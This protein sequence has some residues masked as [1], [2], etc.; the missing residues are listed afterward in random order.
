MTGGRT[1]RSARVLMDPLPLLALATLAS[2]SCG[3]HLAGKADLVPKTVHT[4]SVPPFS[5]ATTRYRL[6]DWLPE[7]ISREFISRTRYRIVSDP[8]QA[9]AVVRGSVLNY[10]SYPT[11]LDP[12]TGRASAIEMHVLM[13]VSL[14]ERATGRVIFS[15]PAFEIQ[16]RYQIS[17]DAAAYFEESDAALR[18]VSQ[19]VA[20]QV[21]SAILQSF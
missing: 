11:I 17:I 12:G 18:R 14:V 15:R 2:T 20:R 19:Q 6:T 9:D 13:Q 7:A 4:V 3:Y 8:D 10:T 1:F 21:V 5:N 16:E